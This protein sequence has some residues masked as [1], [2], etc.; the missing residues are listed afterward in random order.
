MRCNSENP[1]I[2]GVFC[3]R[4]AGHESLGEKDVLGEGRH[5]AVTDGDWLWW[6]A[7]KKKKHKDVVPDGD[8][9]G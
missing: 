5:G 7:S 8:L 3:E 4:E 2:P 9:F 6:K 1:E